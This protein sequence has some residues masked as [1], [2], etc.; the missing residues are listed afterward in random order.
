MPARRRSLRKF[1]ITGAL[2]CNEGQKTA[3]DITPDGKT[4]VAYF[5]MYSKT[6]NL[7]VYPSS[8]LSLLRKTTI[9]GSVMRGLYAAIYAVSNT[10]VV[11]SYYDN[12]NKTLKVAR[13]G[14]PC[15]TPT[16]A[17]ISDTEEGLSIGYQTSIAVTAAGNPVIAHTDS[18]GQ[19]L[20]LTLCDDPI[21]GTW[22]NKRIAR[23]TSP[24]NEISVAVRSDDRPVIAYAAVPNGDLNVQT[25][26]V[27]ICADVRCSST[28]KVVLDSKGSP[29]SGIDMKLDAT[30][31]PA[32]SYTDISSGALRYAR[33]SDAAC[34]SVNTVGH[35]TFNVF[36][37]RTQIDFHI[38]TR[39]GVQPVIS[40]WEYDGF[41]KISTVSVIRCN[42]VTCATIDGPTNVAQQDT[43]IG[44]SM[45]VRGETTVISYYYHGGTVWNYYDPAFPI[46]TSASTQSFLLHNGTAPSP[47]TK[48]APAVNSMKAYGEM[49]RASWESTADA[50]T[51]EYCFYLATSSCTNWKSSANPIA[52]FPAANTGSYLWQVR[53]VNRAGKT[54]ANDGTPWPLNVVTRTAT[55][56][57][58]RTRTP[59]PFY[60][61]APAN[62]ATGVSSS[63]RLSWSSSPSAQGYE[64]CVSASTICRSW[65]PVTGTSVSPPG[66]LR[67]RVYYWQ[68]RAKLATPGT[69]HPAS[70]GFWKFTTVR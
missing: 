57:P 38:P 35:D 27:L 28:S 56:T 8:S 29:G 41:N 46:G 7:A 54:L 44:L 20:F 55:R 45:R 12:V 33:C 53:A 16:I 50:D 61:S 68:V 13:C 26:N 52:T 5:D 24:T 21:C 70:G 67:G 42:D 65:T 31:I 69:Y 34:S 17:S 36:A 37:D 60:K 39:G 23:E 1:P 43:G 59:G 22:T 58:T 19:Y 48:L 49:I 66:L 9:D 25:A 11:M 18:A 14:I 3:V 30:N 2:H 63:V 32:F 10:S 47:F 51:F 4:V 15:T 62:N 6:F 40:F 64:Y